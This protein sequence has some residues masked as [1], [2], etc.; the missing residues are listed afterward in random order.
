MY[1]VALVKG[2]RALLHDED[3]SMGMCRQST[4]NNQVIKTSAARS[5]FHLGASV[6]SSG[7]ENTRSQRKQSTL[8]RST[9]VRA[10]P[11]VG[12]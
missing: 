12:V 6:V 9:N 4:S 10:W 2:S 1:F 5:A 8:C 3:G 11:L 7:V